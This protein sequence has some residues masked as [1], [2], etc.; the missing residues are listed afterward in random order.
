MTIRVLI[1]D[2]SLVMRRIL[3]SALRLA[4]PH[5]TEVL[6]AANGVEGLAALENSAAANQPL[7]LILCDLHMPVMD[8]ID[9]LLQKQQR[10]LAPGVP[11]L[12]MSADAGDP[13]L[14]QAVAAGA[15]G[16]LTKPFTLQQIQARVVALLRTDGK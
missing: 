7:N 3:E 13:R 14:L 11:L 4:V 16:F 12:M 5:L 9:F 15:Q 8:G 6:H 1:L 2:D 10:N